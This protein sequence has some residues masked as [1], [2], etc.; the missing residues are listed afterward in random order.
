MK[1]VS[2]FEEWREQAD[3][4]EELEKKRQE[5]RNEEARWHAENQPCRMEEDLLHEYAHYAMEQELFTLGDYLIKKYADKEDLWYMEGIVYKYYGYC[6]MY[7]RQPKEAVK[8]LK[9]AVRRAPYPY[10][11]WQDLAGAYIEAGMFG[12]ADYWIRRCVRHDRKEYGKLNP[13]TS[14]YFGKFYLDSEQYEKAI[15][16]LE[17]GGMGD[18]RINSDSLYLAKAYIGIGQV[19]RGLQLYEV[20][21]DKYTNDDF[22]YAELALYWH[23]LK[24]DPDRSEMYYLKCISCDTD[25]KDKRGWYAQAYRNLS[26]VCANFGRWEKSFQYLRQYFLYKY[27]EVKADIF[28]QVIDNLPPLESDQVAGQYYHAV[29]AFENDP[30]VNTIAGEESESSVAADPA[31]EVKDAGKGGSDLSKLIDPD[32]IFSN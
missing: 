25:R 24:F 7:N 21:L 9:K 31:A 29:L 12:K 8:W 28:T 16:V 14:V 1:V 22:V 18:T 5:A 20:Y 30:L 23:D 2:W 11:L 32:A 19:D 10:P 3:T 13:H 6:C 26:T 17:E 15:T 4:G 27:D